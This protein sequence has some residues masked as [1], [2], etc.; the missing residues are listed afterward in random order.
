MTELRGMRVAVTGGAR[1]IGRA[2]AARL[3]QAGAHVVIGDRDLELAT[4]VGAE[5]GVV[6]LPLDVTS[7]GSWESFAGEAGAVDVLV[8]N[9]GIMPLGPL[10]E[11]PDEVTRRIFEVNVYGVILGTKAFAPGMVERRRGQLVNIASAVGRLATAH[12]ATYSASKFAVVG[13]SEAMR[14]ELRPYGVD[15]SLVL[16]TVVRT[17]LAAGVPQA[18]FVRQ[19]EPEDVAEVIEAT[20]RSPRPEM[21]VPRWTQGLQR[22][23]SVLPRPVQATLARA[24]RSDSVLTGADPAA[25]AAYEERARRG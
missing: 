10:V 21:W 8:N 24:F 2:T 6:A 12:G 20:I 9:A 17:E 14:E 5:L 25:R 23:V 19:V 7:A 3:A 22:G 4:Q 11:E 18:R 15:V 1:G 13:F 16:P